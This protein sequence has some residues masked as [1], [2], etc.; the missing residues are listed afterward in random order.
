MLQILVERERKGPS[1]LELGIAALL[2]MH[3]ASRRVRRGGG[4]MTPALQRTGRIALTRTSCPLQV[5]DNE[6]HLTIRKV[7]PTL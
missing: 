7:H 2:V 6:F 1:F 4:G 3:F 5:T